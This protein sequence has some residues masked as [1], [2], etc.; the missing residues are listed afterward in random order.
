MKIKNYSFEQLPYSKL[1]KTYVEDFQSLSDFYEVDPFRL[2]SVKNHAAHPN[3]KGNREASAEILEEINRN[4]KVGGKTFENIERLKQPDSITV[5]TGQQLGVY[6]GPLFTVLKIITAIHL[7]ENLEEEL[8]RPVIPVFWLAD[9]DHDY[10]EIR[11]I[12]LLRRDDL[13][14]VGLPQVDGHLPSVAKM[15]LPPGLP[16]I[17][18]EIRKILI[19]T[20]F[21]DDLWKLLDNSYKEGTT[22]EQAFGDLVA[23]L[24]SGHG[25]VL[26]GSNNEMIK[27]NSKG[28]LKEAIL[29]AGDMRD[30]LDRQTARISSDFHQQ[31]TLYDS[32]LFYLDRE[33]GRV[34]IKRNGDGWSAE[35]GYE[36]STNELL[37]EID[38]SPEDFSPNVF[39]RP[40]MQD[41]FLPTLGY[42]AGPGEIAY[43]GQMKTYYSC[44]GQTMPVIFPRLSATFIE[45]AIERIIGELPFDFHEYDM[46]IEDLE[47]AYVERTE[48]HD[49]EAVFSEWKE[50]VEDV[51]KKKTEY[52][53]EVDSTL[54]GAAGKA[55]AVYFG[56]LDKLKGKVYRAV[57]QQDQTQLNRIRKMKANLFPGDALQERTIASIYFMNKYGVDI[58]DRV[59]DNMDADEELQ[60]HKLIY[61]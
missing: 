1:F 2:A 37:E 23:Q 41:H 6:G 30:A 56:E 39:L 11:S 19:D 29:K 52:I 13:K 44:F 7:S 31:V 27:K 8:G 38:T 59:L 47:S 50:K 40:I 42:V 12:S 51:S 46:R 28:V 21:S 43:Y 61:L 16:D 60:Y 32:N 3:F 34:K 49:I 10:E 33:N 54:E 55:T 45:P 25:L 53:R 4:Y 35:T 17:K 15:N 18:K 26:A 48:Q 24:F 9:E 36:W 58:W 57:K 22:F 5:V 20:D 14:K